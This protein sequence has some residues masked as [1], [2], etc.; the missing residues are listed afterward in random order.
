MTL[1]ESAGAPVQPAYCSTPADLTMMG[2]ARVPVKPVSPC[3]RVLPMARNFTCARGV[4]RP[5]IEDIYTLH[6]SEDFETLKTSGLLE[7]GRDGTGG[8]TGTEK[9]VKALDLC[10]DKKFTS[11]QLFPPL[12]NPPIEIPNSLISPPLPFSSL[13]PKPQSSCKLR[14]VHTKLQAASSSSS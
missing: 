14:E 7:I 5:H 13:W 9:V 10:H 12:K 11:A 4:Q 1:W 8:G 3:S 2:L 6:L